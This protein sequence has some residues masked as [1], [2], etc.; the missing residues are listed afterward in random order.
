M[1]GHSRFL[2]SFLHGVKLVS[3]LSGWT[4]LE[5]RNEYLRLCFCSLWSDLTYIPGL[6]LYLWVD[7]RRMEGRCT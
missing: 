6:V 3:W 1:E 2:F 5:S 7:L 4:E